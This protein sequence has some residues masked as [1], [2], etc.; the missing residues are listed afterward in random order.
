[1][2]LNEDVDWISLEKDKCN[3]EKSALRFPGKLSW[4]PT[5]K[6]FAISDTGQHRILITDN[7][8]VVQVKYT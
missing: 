6:R 5:G 7:Q 3:A 2:K 1:M 4:D 8:G